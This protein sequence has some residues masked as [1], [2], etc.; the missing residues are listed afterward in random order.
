MISDTTLPI[1][2]SSE[3]YIQVSMEPS[4]I[5]IPALKNYHHVM[6]VFRKLYRD[7]ERATQD[8]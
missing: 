5:E 2:V 7:F 8:D 6:Q 1:I 4:G 3:V